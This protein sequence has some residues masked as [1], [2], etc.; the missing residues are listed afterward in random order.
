MTVRVL[1]LNKVFV[2]NSVVTTLNFVV[3]SLNSMIVTINLVRSL[4]NE[5]NTHWYMEEAA[6]MNSSIR[7]AKHA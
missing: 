4:L 1:K 6:V 7:N 3:S 5:R 2:I